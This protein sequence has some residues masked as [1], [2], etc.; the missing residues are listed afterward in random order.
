M[1]YAIQKCKTI[2]I[3]EKGHC[4]QLSIEEITHIV[5]DGYVCKFYSL[6]SE[7]PSSC[8]KLLKDLNDELVEYGFIRIN[9]NILINLKY[10][11]AI[12]KTSHIVVLKGCIKLN[13]SR[14]KWYLIKAVFGLWLELLNY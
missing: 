13:V 4:K 10:V 1:D 2:A 14:R 5:S 7:S 11:E 6:G 12:Q 8:R 9:H 3:K